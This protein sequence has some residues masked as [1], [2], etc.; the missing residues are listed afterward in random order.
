MNLNFLKSAFDKIG[1]QSKQLDRIAAAT[2]LTAASVTVG[3]VLFTKMDEMVKLLRVIA[4]NG[5]AS[6][7]EAIKDAKALAIVGN[8]MEPLGKGFQ[9]L[10]QALNE[11]PD[12]KEAAKKMDALVGGLVKLGEIGDAIVSFAFSMIIATPLLVVSALLAPIWVPGLMVMIKGLMYA[13]KGLDKKQLKN[14]SLLGDVG[15]SILVLGG[16]LALLS[17]VGMQM[18]E[19]TI[20]AS[21][22][23]LGIA[24]VIS[25]MNEM[26]DPKVAKKQ[27]KV[28]QE[29]TFSI[30]L[31]GGTFAL[32]SLVGPQILKGA[33]IAAGALLIIGGVLALANKFLDPAKIDSFANSVKTLGLGLLALGG[34]LFIFSLI[35][36]QAITG[37][38]YAVAALGIIAIGMKIFEKLGATV[39][40]G[41]SKQMLD[42]GLG[43]LAL[44]AT[45]FLVSLVGPQILKGAFF[46]AGAIL[47]IGGTFWLL[48]KMKILDKIET[49]AK[50]L[51]RT[52]IA[53]LAIGVALA[54]FDLVAPPPEKILKIGLIIGGVAVAFGIIGIFGDTIL[55]GA[56]A[57]GFAALAIFALGLSLYLFDQLVPGDILSMETLKAFIVVGAI[58]LGFYLA[59][60]GATTILKGAIAMAIAGVALIIIGF[61]IS[62]LDAA[63]PKENAWERIAQMGA[64]IGG[65]GI[66]MALA[67][68]VAGNI[69]LGAVAM[70]VAG[71]SL[72]LIGVGLKVLDSSL[73]EKDGWDRIA[74]MGAIIGGLA[75][76]MAAAGF[77]A[78]FILLGSAAMMVAGISMVLVAIGVK[79][80]ADIDFKKMF[81][82]GGLFADSGQKTKGFLGIGGGRPKTNMEVMFEAI[83]D[84][85]SLGPLQLLGLYTGAPAFIMAG[86]ALLTIGKGIAEF[87][88]IAE[89]TDLK[90]LNDNV[91]M[92]VTSLSDSFAR[93]GI[94]YPGGGGSIFGGGSVVAQGV[95][96]T[97]GMGRALTGIA[98]GM[99]AMANLQFPV[100]FD[101][102]GNPIKFESMNSDAPMKVAA[103][104]AM[105]T[106]VLANVF[107]EI[108]TKYPGGK[109]GLFD[110]IFGGGQQSPVADG[111]SAVMGMGD[112]LTGIAKGFQSMANLN[113]PVEWDKDGKPTKF[114]TIDINSSLPLV[115]ANTWAIVTGLSSVFAQIGK[116]P[117]AQ[118]NG[119]F[120]KS[121]IQKG[122]DIVAGIGTPLFN[123]AKGV[124]DIANLKF[125]T[126]FD[127]DGKATGYETIT[128]PGD[129]VARVGSNTALLIEALV[130]TFT[131]I[132]GGPAGDRGDLW[133]WEDNAFDKG[134][135]IVSQIAE[136]YQKLSSSIK[137]VVEV[138]GN[139][140]TK[141]FAGK[142]IDLV[143]VFVDA[144]QM[145]DPAMGILMMTAMGTSFEKLG[146]AVPAVVQALGSLNMETSAAFRGVFFGAVDPKDPSKSYSTQGVA[147]EK[148]GVAMPSIASNMQVTAGAINAMDLEKLTEARTMFEA[149]ATL[150][151]GGDAS[152][153]LSQMGESLEMALQNLATMLAE[154]KDTVGEAAAGQTEATGMLS[155]AVEGV[156]NAVAGVTGGGAAGKPAGGKEAAQKPIDVSSVVRAIQT[157]QNQLTSQGIKVRTI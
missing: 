94:L 134:V 101:K 144:G 138:V 92:I 5:A 135:K 68:A 155:G 77:A 41:F 83:A 79:A 111:I 97:L 145:S 102:E 36:M 10:V 63:I 54:L 14:I 128:S 6:G 16:S 51:L 133:F 80:F 115:M 3:G 49:G 120:G 127:K 88:K 117:D 22:M 52:A 108:G 140:D 37:A 95:S 152:T 150:T 12:G 86:M 126:G 31:L 69:I 35:G 40:E 74:Q 91:N 9:I 56:K 125:P 76:A 60:Q 104:A 43:L 44:G 122:I 98:R 67:G 30:L 75:L 116:N 7:K 114:E 17:L 47:I 62:M 112:A 20:Y 113:F 32:F 71:V 93:I 34:A 29:F 11:L 27:A 142:M 119:W 153:I 23:L 4:N 24:K 121:T 19:G 84:S 46:A 48:D 100:E 99:Q 148:I 28:L 42:L 156:K 39:E 141:T 21:M 154:F 129:L 57:M 146:S 55:K 73:P 61:G 81:S 64:I 70:A 109:K 147:W 78:P 89:K 1:E 90:S 143:K 96:A 25:I 131:Q 139:M 85:M 87:Q 15:L 33:L 58:G 157:L 8:S 105:I 137:D 123:L 130:S 149:L 18:I 66:A 107:G 118:S 65:L 103:N 82:S 72:I 38:L 59:G 110:S 124:Q 13:T 53:I 2:E 50:A 106:S 132:G 136:P 26:V 45:L 151:H